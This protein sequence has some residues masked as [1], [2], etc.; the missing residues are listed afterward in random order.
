MV[1]S[2]IK[3]KF[4][5]VEGAS[6]NLFGKN[7][8][9]FEKKRLIEYFESHYGENRGSLLLAKGVIEHIFYTRCKSTAQSR[10]KNEK[11]EEISI[12]DFWAY[13]TDYLL[14]SD[15]ER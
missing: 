13:L 6:M 5:K 7:S 2:E 1:K 8:R 9:S 4:A 3:T 10:K 12:D 11:T 14:T 15:R